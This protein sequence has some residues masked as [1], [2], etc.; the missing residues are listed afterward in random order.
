M[1][2]HLGTVTVAP[3][4]LMAL[5]RLSAL[6]T[7]GVAR[8]S[9]QH[10]HSVRRLF[11]GKAREGIRLEIEDQAVSIDLY[12]V[13][14]P[15]VQMLALGQTLQRE[16]SRSIHDMVGMPVKAINIHIEDVAIRTVS[17]AA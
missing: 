2:E 7:P 5:I 4:V 8:L 10:P 9:P 6:A 3:E 11:S 15:D 12:I 13:A 17:A 1:E 14:E 16:I